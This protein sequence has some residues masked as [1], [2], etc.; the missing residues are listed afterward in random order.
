MFILL[1]LFLKKIG[2]LLIGYFNEVFTHAII[3]CLIIERNDILP[4]PYPLGSSEIGSTCE[5][6]YISLSFLPQY[7][8]NNGSEN[9]CKQL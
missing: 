5:D 8:Y 1:N 9:L 3:H 2:Y 4:C 7:Q 6:W